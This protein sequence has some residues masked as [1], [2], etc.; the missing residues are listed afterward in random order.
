[1][2]EVERLSV[3]EADGT[4]IGAALERVRSGCADLGYG[5][6]RRVFE[7]LL[8]S[9]VAGS[10]AS[11]LTALHAR[12]ES[13]A[14]LL[15]GIHTVRRGLL[16]IDPGVAGAIDVG[17]TGGDAF[18]TFN[19]STTAS[20]VVAAAAQPVCKHGS[21]AVSGV[22]GSIDVLERLGVP[23]AVDEATARRDLALNG[24]A[25]LPSSSFLRYPPELSALRRLLGVR[26][27]FNLVGPWCN[28]AGVTRQIVGTSRPREVTL[29]ARIARA[30]GHQRALIVHGCDGSLDEFSPAGASLVAE[31]RDG[32]IETSTLYPED[33]GLRRT[34]LENASGGEGLE[35]HALNAAAVLDGRDRAA[36]RVMTLMTVG[37]ALYVADRVRTLDRRGDTRRGGHRF[38]PGPAPARTATDTGTR[39]G[40]APRI[41]S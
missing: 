34:P 39:A 31:L 23:V 27:A 11:F 38:R 20:I 18:R 16:T 30:L 17:G 6:S 29:F 37:A 41:R 4:A 14:E 32:H 5:A 9:P 33:L 13:E 10:A 8:S 40:T 24:I 28:P 26:T 19:V 15:A 22:C 21:R 35:A 12:G 36:R 2:P 3:P 7:Q 25:F 1:M